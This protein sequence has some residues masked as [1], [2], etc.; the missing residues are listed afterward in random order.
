[1]TSDDCCLLTSMY[2]LPY[3]QVTGEQ[4]IRR[5]DDSEPVVRKRLVAFRESTMAVVGYFSGRNLHTRIDGTK[6]P[7]Q[8]F[9][10]VTKVLDARA[11]SKPASAGGGGL[12]GALRGLLPSSK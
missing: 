3:V 12:L 8:V 5:E 7:D 4:L 11:D 10:A 6:T 9:Q 2:V 1:M